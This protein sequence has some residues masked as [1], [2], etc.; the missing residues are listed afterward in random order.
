MS[1][2][3]HIWSENFRRSLFILLILSYGLAQSQ[4]LIPEKRPRDFKPSILKLSYDVIP[5]GVTMVSDKKTRQGFQA[6]MDFDQFFFAVEYGTESTVRGETFEYT[7]DGYHF[8]FG[9][10][11]NMLKNSTNGNALTFGFRYG[12][13]NFNETLSYIQSDSSFFGQTMINAR[14]PELVARWL[15]LTLGI[16]ANVW[17]NLYL[18]YTVRYKVF[19]S[20]KGIEEFAPYDVPGFGL[21]EDNNGVRFNFYVGW[22]IPLREK[23]PEET[24]TD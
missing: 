23:Y 6:T 4:S 11:I 1:A 10:E 13:A 15:E 7:N 19:R 18:G 2:V 22:A 16:Q 8:S 3:V 17:K 14:N 12:Q 5:L 24:L 20:V 21:Y 9:P